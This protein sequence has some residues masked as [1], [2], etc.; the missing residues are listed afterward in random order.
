LTGHLV[1]QFCRLLQ[2]AWA[3]VALGDDQLALIVDF[4]AQ[5][6]RTLHRVTR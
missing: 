5:H 3:E 2:E 1:P 4:M 6:A